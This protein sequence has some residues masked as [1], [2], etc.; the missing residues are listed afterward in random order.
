MVLLALVS[1]MGYWSYR[2]IWVRDMQDVVLA[3]VAPALI[4][5]GAPWLPLTRG[6]GLRRRDEGEPDGAGS[7][8]GGTGSGQPGW[9]TVPVLATVV[10]SVVWWVWH[11]PG[12]FDAA[13]RSP[14]IYAAEAVTYL[15]CGHLALAPADRVASAESPD[16]AAEQGGP[17]GGRG[18][19]RHGAR[20]DPRVRHGAGVSRRTSA[21]VIVSPASSLTSRSAGGSYG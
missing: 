5:L 9:L 17:R 14:A 7:E 20:A 19:I 11:M 16:G 12:P 2:V 1:P 8:T 18:R 21:W 10:F 13:L 6:L 15:A 3:I 4:V